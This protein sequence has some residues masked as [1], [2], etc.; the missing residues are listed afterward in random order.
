MKVRQQTFL[1]SMDRHLF[2]NRFFQQFHSIFT[3]SLSGFQA[4]HFQTFVF[5]VCD[6]SQLAVWIESLVSLKED[7]C[8]EIPV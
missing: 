4:F 7:E 8:E 1:D 3:A 5:G 6:P 2:L